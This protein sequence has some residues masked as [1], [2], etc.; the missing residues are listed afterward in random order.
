[1]EYADALAPLRQR[2][3]EIMDALARVPARSAEAAR[4]CGE[5][6]E[7]GY[8]LYTEGG[9]PED[10][11]LADEAFAHALRH[12]GGD[13]HRPV[14]QIMHGHL[15]AIRYDSEPG[16]EPELADRIHA[17]LTEGLAGL[18]RDP[19]AGGREDAGDHAVLGRRLLANAARL[20]RADRPAEP[21]LLEE[22]L[23]HHERAREDDPADQDLLA[24][25][26]ELWLEHGDSAADPG[27][28]LRAAEVFGELL[29][30]I[31]APDGGTAR[32]AT[33]GTTGE[34][35]GGNTAE[36]AP[37]EPDPARIR[38]LRACGLALS[39]YRSADR[40][41][42]EDARDECGRAA[43]ALSGRSGA[44]P[45]W[46][47]PLARLSLFVRAVIAATWQEEPLLSRVTAELLQLASDGPEMDDMPVLYLDNFGRLL[48]V[49]GQPSVDAEL[50]DAAIGVLERALDRWQA[51]DGKPT[52]AALALGMAQF[53]REQRDG[54][55]DRLLGQVRAARL[56]LADEE[57]A[58]VVREGAVI[59]LAVAQERLGEESPDVPLDDLR[60]MFDRFRQSVF[61]G[62]PVEFGFDH[63][64]LADTEEAHAGWER[65]FAAMYADWQRAQPGSRR[66]AEYAAH[67]LAMMPMLDAHLDRIGP[68]REAEMV[69]AVRQ[70][71]EQHPDWR[72][73][74]LSVLGSWRLAQ[75]LAGDT[76]RLVES[77]AHFEAAV[78]AG[79]TNPWTMY[80][81]RTARIMLDQH[82]GVIGGSVLD[83]EE[84]EQL[85]SAL[86]P[87]PRVSLLMRCQ[88][89]T[90]QAIRAA[91]RRDLETTDRY[92][93]MLEQAV[94]ELGDED[95]MQRME[96][97]VQLETVRQARGDLAER[98]GRPPLPPL[99]GRPTLAEL[100][101]VGRKFPRHHR[102]D[103]LGNMALARMREPLR[104]GDVP[105]LRELLALTEEAA[106]LA[107]EG[108]ESWIR[109]ASE[110]G[111]LTCALAVTWPPGSPQR[112]EDLDRG[113]G[114]LEGTVSAM[115]GPE[116][117]LWSVTA[118]SLG[119]AL[120]TRNRLARRDRERGRR[121]GLD[122]LRGFVWSAL[123]QSG[124]QDVAEAARLATDL[125]QEVVGWC[126]A[127]GEAEEA[128]QA[129]DSCRGLILHAATTGRSVAEQLA[130]AGRDDLAERWRT[131]AAG[132]GPDGVPGP[133][134]REV[135]LALTEGGGRRLL[136]PPGPEE[137]AGALRSVGKD[138]LVYLVPGD[139][140]CPGTALIVTSHGQVH[141]LPL[142][143]LRA[144]APALT[145]Y[146]PHAR[147][148]QRAGEERAG[149]RDMEPVPGFGGSGVAPALRAQLD[150]LCS[151]AWQAAVR[152]LLDLFEVPDRPGRV[153]RLVLVPM[154]PLGPVPWH[155]AWADAP[156]AAD[157]SPGRRYAIQKAEFSYAASAR[158]LCEVAARPAVPH[159]GEALVVGDPTGDLPYA[160]TEAE[161]VHRVFY[162]GGTFLG[163][164]TG[165]G[166][167]AEVADWLRRHGGDGAVVH[168]ACHGTVFENQPR[169][170][171]LALRGGELTA[172]EITGSLPGR[173]GLVVLAACRSQVSGRGHN[174]AYSLSSAFLVAG[175]RSVIGS[176]WPVPDDATSV[177]MFLTHHFLR[178]E[179][180]APARALR[181]AQLWMLD[182]A[183][184]VPQDLPGALAGRLPRLDPH[185]L[186][187]W[188][189]FTHLGQ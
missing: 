8:V 33:G 152:P 56:V 36:A 91:R 147:P 104:R 157:G 2:R 20:R 177:L 61:E 121:L 114:L 4:L 39:G 155:A 28:W 82:R 1:M 175:S 19:S 119:R 139:D 187:A 69:E 102:A 143:H 14:R 165:S 142:P 16:P 123:L 29:A 85:Q 107:V 118:H 109:F 144:A 116:H 30:V 74:G 124:T 160:G 113:I 35:T 137:M 24:A 130:A 167:P 154:G 42:L 97:W 88:Q 38:F 17:V 126:L 53:L 41:V 184:V 49:R 37:E 59:L 77:V 166:S 132:A 162:P 12:P 129:L 108:G 27:S 110:A 9:D 140:K 80:G 141:T 173:P 133:L 60:P 51:T 34:S 99:T 186:S 71:A 98:L 50:L 168:L 128:V 67:A 164:R 117:R 65:N 54:N 47:T 120:R 66:S 181:R 185:D 106:S 169:S 78:A 52:L 70:H 156:P 63:P 25:L 92:C 21:A 176:L 189:G 15:L 149:D 174:E 55:R 26:G 96:A 115:G 75:G 145:A 138:A 148:G 161:A 111:T 178:R 32:E 6:G 84:W 76:E 44:P 122:A 163:L 150:R 81:Y 136:D 18:D 171:S 159:T 93:V 101:A 46:A 89:A 72:G 135:V 127:D 179:G 112:A 131:A 103:L 170:S 188:A 100:R 31:G 183:R 23:R 43:A 64:T 45:A 146:R 13:P 134:R 79:H 90:G 94:A 125:S 48:F 95:P 10:L 153:P 3:E 58:Q 5:A 180:E 86:G 68:E 40:A 11:E 182:P 105:Q 151:W 87:S 172:E 22:A 73:R 7:I 62:A 158:L 83:E 57:A